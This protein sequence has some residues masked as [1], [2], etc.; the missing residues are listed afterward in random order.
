MKRSKIAGWQDVFRF[1]IAQTLK[2]RA[3]IVS[4]IIMM[5]LSLVSMPLISKITSSTQKEMEYTITKAYVY[6]MTGL[7]DLAVMEQIEKEA[8]WKDIVFEKKDASEYGTEAYE[9]LIAEIDEKRTQEIVISVQVQEG[10]YTVLFERSGE[11]DVTATELQSFG[12]IF[13]MKFDEQKM[14]ALNLTEEQL[15]L[16][17]TGVDTAVSEV[18]MSGKVLIELDTSISDSESWVLYALLFFSMMVCTL[19]GS[20]VATSIVTEKSTKVVEYLLTSV[21]PMAIMVGKVFAML[22]VV[23]TQVIGMILML[24][25]SNVISTSISGG[26]NLLEK[27]LTE[28]IINSLTVGNVI[29]GVIM[30]ALGLI[31]YATLA[32]LAGATVSKLEEAGEGMTMLTLTVL[33][34]AYLGIGAA[35]TLLSSGANAFTTFV[36]VFPLSSP[37]VLPGAILIG[38]AELWMIAVSLVLLIVLILLLF[39]FISR[40]YE[41]LIVYN[42]SKVGIKKLIQMGRK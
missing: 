17:E 11:G 32:G 22:C 15:A 8:G 39:A 42:G 37:F 23:L 5:L 30:L 12:E 31:F 21:R 3:F 27:Y 6:D 4:F 7:A 9:K 40:V 26:E 19:V 34:G 28:D 41:A 1:T 13:A 35:A 16:L 20:Q 2:S 10:L 38:E 36:L 18:D 24:V 14:A 29:F 25:A 33:I